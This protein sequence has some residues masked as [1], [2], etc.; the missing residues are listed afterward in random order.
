MITKAHYSFLVFCVEAPPLHLPP[1]L[2]RLAP[3]LDCARLRFL[4]FFRRGA[5]RPLAGA[6]AGFDKAC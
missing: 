1:L 3:D 6:G 4:R 2:L 5:W